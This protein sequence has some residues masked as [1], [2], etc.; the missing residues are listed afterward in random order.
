VT[1]QLKSEMV[2][3][4]TLVRKLV[5]RFGSE[6]LDVVSQ[7]TIEQARVALEEADIARRDLDSVMELLWD[8]M[9][10]GTEF[11][12]V[13][14]SPEVLKISVTKC[15]FADEMRRLGAADIGSTFYCSYD[16]GFCQGLNRQSDSL[17]REH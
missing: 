15:L 8:Q 3:R 5:D 16:R 7:H 12:V 6:V 11:E 9:G 13:E 4:A 10:S 17:E 14:R 1:E 2:N